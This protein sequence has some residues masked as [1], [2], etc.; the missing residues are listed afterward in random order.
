LL[1]SVPSLLL[2]LTHTLRILHA[3]CFGLRSYTARLHIPAFTLAVPDAR[4]VR[5][6]T[7]HYTPATP[8]LLPRHHAS[9]YTR[10][11]HSWIAAAQHFC[12]IVHTCGSH[13]GTPTGPPLHATHTR[14]RGSLTTP[15]ATHFLHALLPPPA[16][17][18]P[19]IRC[20]R[21]AALLLDTA[22]NF[23]LHRRPFFCR[24]SSVVRWMEVLPYH[25]RLLP[26]HIPAPHHRY[27]LPAWISYMPSTR[28]RGLPA[29]YTPHGAHASYHLCT[30]HT[31][32][33]RSVHRTVPAR[34]PPPGCH[35]YGF[36]CCA[37]CSFH[38]RC[39]RLS[40]AACSFAHL[41]FHLIPAAHCWFSAY[42]CAAP[43]PYTTFLAAL[44][45]R[46]HR[47]YHAPAGILL[48]ITTIPH[49]ARRTR[50]YAPFRFALLPH[51]RCL[52]PAPPGPT[53]C[54]T[55]APHCCL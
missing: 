17:S 49:R 33:R 19:H 51:V 15:A 28:A 3:P 54:R 47:H 12:Y 6:A 2:Y 9:A 46:C 50:H 22:R 36:H 23:L 48:Y 11:P 20:R 40:L 4:A 14:T 31:A 42:T 41:R 18:A 53:T 26:H 13:S 32:P 21:T 52:L 7:F 35:L 37:H 38:A 27:G 30:V 39:R 24:L 45:G 34:L 10:V 8:C 5:D 44:P 25:Y 1:L 29:L 43:P 16:H 55:T